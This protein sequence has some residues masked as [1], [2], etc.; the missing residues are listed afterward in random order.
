VEIVV[1]GKLEF[2]VVGVLGELGLVLVEYFGGL[3][4]EEFGI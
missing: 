4:C 3:K 2:L 1:L